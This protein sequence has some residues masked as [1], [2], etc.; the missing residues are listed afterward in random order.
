MRLAS[1]PEERTTDMREYMRKY[2]ARK[3]EER[4]AEGPE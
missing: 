4:E 2:R 3:R 1:D